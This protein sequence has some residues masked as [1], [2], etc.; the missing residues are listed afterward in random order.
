MPW[1]KN[2]PHSQAGYPSSHLVRRAAL[3]GVVCFGPDRTAKRPAYP[4]R[5]GEFPSTVELGRMR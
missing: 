4:P 5:I 2:R 3:E 1:G